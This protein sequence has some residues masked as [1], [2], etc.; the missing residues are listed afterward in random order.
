[1]HNIETGILIG[2]SVFI[3]F[4]LLDILRGTSLKDFSLSG[5][6]HSIKETTMVLLFLAGMFT[7][8]AIVTWVLGFFAN[9]IMSLF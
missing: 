7:L 5:I 8:V 9:A 1:M 3:L 6:I 2:M 4:E